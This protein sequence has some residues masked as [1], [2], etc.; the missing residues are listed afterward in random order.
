MAFNMAPFRQSFFWG[1]GQ[2]Q[3]NVLAVFVVF[4]GEPPH[5][6]AGVLGMFSCGQLQ[7]NSLFKKELTCFVVFSANCSVTIVLTKKGMFPSVLAHL[8]PKET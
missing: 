8:F 3:N 2:L 5:F 6:L 1:A 4:W 7:N